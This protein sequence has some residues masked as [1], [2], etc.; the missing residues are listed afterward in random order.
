MEIHATLNHFLILFKF[1]RIK[2]INAEELL[3]RDDV[4]NEDLSDMPPLE[5][6]EE[7]VKSEPEETIAERVKLNLQKNLKNMN[8]IKNLD[9]KQ[10]IK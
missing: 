9:S 6:D 8:R 2:K 10:T 1:K 3:E 5:V 7:Q 4:K